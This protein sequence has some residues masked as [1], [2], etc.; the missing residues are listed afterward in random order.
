MNDTT[1]ISGNFLWIYIEGKSLFLHIYWLWWLSFLTRTDHI[2]PGVSLFLL[3][4][5][6]SINTEKQN[7]QNQEVKRP[8]K[9]RILSTDWWMGFLNLKPEL[10]QVIRFVISQCNQ[11]FFYWFLLFLNHFLVQKAIVQCTLNINKAWAFTNTNDSYDQYKYINQ[12]IKSPLIICGLETKMQCARLV[13]RPKIG[14]QILGFYWDQLNWFESNFECLTYSQPSNPVL[15]KM[16][17]MER[18]LEK[19]TI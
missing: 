3:L 6:I 16:S 12:N 18:Q 19:L 14:H 17:L 15:R 9:S 5:S 13:Q 8:I 2:P 4:D 10:F 1:R 11:L 7:I